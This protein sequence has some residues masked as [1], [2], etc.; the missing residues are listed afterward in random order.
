MKNSKVKVISK[1]SS[2]LAIS[3][4]FAT[5]KNQKLLSRDAQK[6]EAWLISQIRPRDKEFHSYRIE[7]SQLR[8]LCNVSKS[9]SYAKLNR[10]SDE[11]LTH[12]V[13]IKEDNRL[14]KYGLIS[15]SEYHIGEGWCEMSIHPDL[16]PHMLNLKA[17]SRFAIL[18]LFISWSFV[19]VYSYPLYKYLKSFI[20]AGN[21]S[22][23]IE[24]MLDDLKGSLG[25]LNKYE[26]FSNFKKKVLEPTK[27][28][29]E[30]KADIY[31]VYEPAKKNKKKVISIIFVIKRKP[32]L[33]SNLQDIVDIENNNKN[34]IDVEHQQIPLHFKSNSE[35]GLYNDLEIL[36]FSGDIST[37]IEEVGEHNI[38]KA[39]KDVHEAQQTGNINSPAA[40]LRAKANLYNRQEKAKEEVQEIKA[41]K[42]IE[43][44]EKRNQRLVDGRAEL[45]KT[46]IFRVEQG[47]ANSE[48]EAFFDDFRQFKSIEEHNNTYLKDGTKVIDYLNN[49]NY[50][51]IYDLDDKVL[52]MFLNWKSETLP[53]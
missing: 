52:A 28:E 1:K 45:N 11:L 33:P 23:Q 49:I 30:E 40:L 17:S 3:N 13:Y 38:I 39:L 6:L 32:K 43:E 48:Q 5:A 19:G 46:Y 51:S 26:N 42:N 29:F 21:D 34:I 15:S 9:Y 4:K 35:L 16:K 44:E 12:V 50:S 10:I 53:L 37:F 47:I 31:F 18:E 25:C 36:G 22:Y 7:A 14:K 41:R 20:H 8:E 27:E 24:I 2:Y